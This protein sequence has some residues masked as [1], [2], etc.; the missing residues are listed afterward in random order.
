[1]SA[2]RLSGSY[3]QLVLLF[4]GN[5]NSDLNRSELVII[6]ICTINGSMTLLLSSRPKDY[7]S[8]DIQVTSYMCNF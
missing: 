5:L 4:I 2:F 7:E 3:F 1:M 6:L 8:H